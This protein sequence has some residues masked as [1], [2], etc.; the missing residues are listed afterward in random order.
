MPGCRE[1]RAYPLW[2]LNELRPY[3]LGTGHWEH[4][5]LS[6]NG[7]GYQPWGV[8]GGASVFAASLDQFGSIALLAVLSLLIH[9]YR[10]FLHLFRSS[11]MYNAV[12]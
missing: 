11:L 1:G 9:E 3:R 4:S 5:K 12:L 6:I 7:R 8:I 2:L 10:M